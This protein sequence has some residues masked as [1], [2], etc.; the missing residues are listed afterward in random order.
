MTTVQVDLV[1][2]REIKNTQ[3]ISISVTIPPPLNKIK[4]I[5]HYGSSPSK[6]QPPHP[7]FSWIQR[8][9]N[10]NFVKSRRLV[11]GALQNSLLGSPQSANDPA[12]HN[13][14]QYSLI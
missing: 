4:W 8:K 13:A 5:N 10:K 1:E 7:I 6:P 12:L 11:A 14:D 9:T 2:L 3:G